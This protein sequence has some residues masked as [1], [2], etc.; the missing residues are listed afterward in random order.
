MNSRLLANL[1]KPRNLPQ[2]D[3]LCR[4]FDYAQTLELM[5]NHEHSKAQSANLHGVASE[6]SGHRMCGTRRDP[7]SPHRKQ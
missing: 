7:T 2:P 1:L 5:R 6:S 3:P 4:T